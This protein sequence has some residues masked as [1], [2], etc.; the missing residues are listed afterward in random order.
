M[1]LFIERGMRGGISMVN[2]RY[3]KAKNPLVEGYNPAE[4]T[5]YITYL[6]ANNLYGWAMSLPLPKSGFHWKRVMPTEEQ[7]MKMKWNSKKGWI[8]EV[9]LEYPEELHDWHNDYPLAPEKK[10]ISPEKMSEYQQRLM[11]DLDLTMPNTEKLVLTLEDKEKYVV[12]YKNLQFYLSQGIRLKKVHRVIEFNQEPWIE[13]YIRMNTEFRRQAKSDFETDF[14]KLMNTSVF[15]KTMENRTDVKIV[16]E[17]ETDKIRK[18]VSSP[19]FDRFCIFG[20]DMAGIHMHKT[21]LVLNKPVH[22]HNDSREQQDLDV[23]LLLQ[24]LE[25]QIRTEL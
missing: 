22:R 9:D 16:R 20:N 5:N 23:R 17:R 19:S 13:P 4:T 11:A 15:G 8:L 14:Y 2:K 25:S 12:H 18:L 1:H 10:V 24:L 21:R 6:D 7:I 3:A